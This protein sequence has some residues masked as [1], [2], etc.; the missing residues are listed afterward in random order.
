MKHTLARLARTAFVLACIVLTAC[1]RVDQATPSGRHPWTIPGHLRIGTLDDPDALIKL[2]G[3]S[4][5]TDEINNLLF[6]PVFRFDQNGELVPELATAVPTYGNG[7]ISKD[8]RTIVLH[9]RKGVVWS[10]GA[11][12]D[13][14]DLRFTWQAVMNDRNNVR[15]RAGWDDITAID[16]PNGTTAIVHLRLPNATVIP[17]CFGGGA[18]PPLPAHLL[19]KYPDINRVAFNQQPI[20]SGPW[21]LRAW[22]R[23]ASLEFVPN[24]RYWR[25]RPKLDALTIK[26]IPDA[27]TLFNALATHE[28][29]VYDAVAESQIPRL[30]SIAGITVAKRLVGNFRHL[31]FNTRNPILA[32]V[33]VRRAIAQAVDWNAINDTIYHGYNVRAHSDIIP[34]SWAAPDI[35]LYRFD[36]DGAARL[37]TQAGWT[38]GTDGLRHRAGRTLRLSVTTGTNK[39]A[40]VQAEVQMQQ[41]VH[42]LGIDLAIKNYPVGYLFAQNGPLYG[43]TYD[44]SWTIDTDGPDPDNQGNWSGAFIP[45][46]GSNTTFYNDPVITQTSEAAL[47]TYDRGRRKAL[48]QREEERIHELVLAVFLY[49]EMSYCAYNSDLHAFKPAQFIA[50]SWNSWEWQI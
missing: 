3:N 39:A 2:F 30:G 7:G 1:T 37:L 18:Y 32:D 25:G 34:T 16:T 31:E 10:D 20:S 17:N 15:S 6:A 46:H 38:M 50:N 42:A 44:M 36:F 11:P 48:Y 26:I 23:S 40:N 19:A 9:L 22:N 35:P 45:P 4:A 14:R 33:R 5:A 43:G 8:G 21:L 29:D 27:E 41:R 28:V 47:R 13:V 24:T 49:W 12:L